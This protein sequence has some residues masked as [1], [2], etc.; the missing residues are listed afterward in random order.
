NDFRSLHQ[1]MLDCFTPGKFSD[2]YYAYRKEQHDNGYLMELVK[3]CQET[4]EKIENFE[5]LFP[6]LIE[7]A[8]LYGDLQVHKHV[9]VEERVPR[10]KNW[11]DEH[12]HLCPDLT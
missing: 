7:L 9:T 11:Y 6:Y 8:T 3:T 10:L 4:V 2:N 1:A 5:M 12:Q